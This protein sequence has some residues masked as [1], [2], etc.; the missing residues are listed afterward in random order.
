MAVWAFARVF[1]IDRPSALRAAYLADLRPD[2]LELRLKPDAGAGKAK[3]HPHGAVIVSFE[4]LGVHRLPAIGAEDR[5][6]GIN[7]GHEWPLD[8]G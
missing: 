4:L 1:Q 2:P 7:G 6:K 5:G 8:R 3:L